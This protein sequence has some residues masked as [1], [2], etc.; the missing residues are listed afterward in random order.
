MRHNTP[1]LYC[2]PVS[3]F[4]S[5]SWPGFSRPSACLRLRDAG[6]L[7]RGYGWFPQGFTPRISRA[8]LERNRSKIDRKT[9]G[10]ADPPCLPR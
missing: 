10:Y 1:V 8:M 7:T 2:S 3:G 5:A 4:L 9:I 6:A